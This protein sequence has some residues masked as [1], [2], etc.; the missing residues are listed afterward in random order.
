MLSKRGSRL[1]AVTAAVL[2]V[3]FVIGLFDLSSW[4]YTKP[5]FVAST[6]NW[7]TAREYHPADRIKDLPR[8]KPKPIPPVQAPASAFKNPRKA[9]PRR[10]EVLRV[11]ERSYDAYRRHAWMRD[12]LAPL[13]AQGKD[14]FGGWAAT[15]IDTL[16]TL[17][18]MGLKTEFYEASAAVAQI[19]WSKTPDRAANVFETTIRHL[20]G[21]LGAYDLSGEKAL[22]AKA[23]ELGEMLYMA[24]DTPNRLPGFWI[25]Y[26]DAENGWQVAGTNDASASPSSLC[27]EF[28]RLSQLTGD[29]KFYDATD[30]V[31]RFL[32]RV[33]YE[34]RLPGMWPKTINFQEE[35]AG[36]SRFTLGG[37]ADSL[38]EYLPKM[39]ALLGGL[40]DTY[41][42]LYLGASETAIRHL[43]YRPMLP[44]GQDIL[45]AGDVRINSQGRITKIPDG[46]HLS[47]FAGGMFSLGGKLFGIPDQVRVG[48]RLARGCGWAYGQFPTGVMPE[49]FSLIPCDSMD[50]CAWDEKKWLSQGNT[51]LNRGWVDARDPRYMLRPEA[52]ESIFLLYRMTGAEDLRDIAWDMFKGI[53]RST[54]T[55]IAYAA[56]RQV[57]DTGATTKEDSM[58]VSRCMGLVRAMTM[59]TMLMI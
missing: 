20:G 18:I 36:S 24:F 6:F 12:E 50:G 45:F 46:Q 48:D 23:V 34:S 32:E 41:G 8:G 47:C 14:T 13:S 39:H 31:T 28:T 25:N 17:W 42:K 40:D 2:F 51:A 58:E 7:A 16:D 38:Y 44:G 19:D 1:V 57:T 3:L 35:R 30:R 52:I 37:E 54:E 33:Q 15:L 4:S 9:D 55:D 43:L 22:L 5:R 11:F 27:L 26:K 10:Q 59:M 21:L 29:P 53:V 56:I 49:K